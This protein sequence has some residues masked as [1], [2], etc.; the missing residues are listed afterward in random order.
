MKRLI[1]PTSVI[2]C[3]WVFSTWAGSP[4]APSPTMYTL[5]DIYNYLNYG[6]TAVAGGHSLEPVSGAVPG[7]VR[8][9]T[10]SQVYND[11]KAKFDQCD[12][13][14]I[15][16]KM[17]KKFFSARPGKWGVQTGSASGMLLQTGTWEVGVVG[18]DGWYKMGRSFDYADNGDGTVS[19]NVTGLMWAKDGAG[20]GCYSGGAITGWSNAI[21]WADGLTFAGYSDW[22]L[23]NIIEME[24]LFY[25]GSGV[26]DGVPYIQTYFPN[27]APGWYY[28]STIYDSDYL[29]HDIYPHYF[30]ANFASGC[31]DHREAIDT[32][33][34]Y[35]RAVRGGE[36]GDVM[37][38]IVQIGT[39]YAATGRNTP[40][41]YNDVKIHHTTAVAWAAG[42][43]YAGY[44]SGWRL[45]TRTELTA[46]CNEREKVRGYASDDYWTSTLQAAG[47]YYTVKFYPLHSCESG[48]DPEDISRNV[49]VVRDS[50]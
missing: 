37:P 28:S 10:T 18:E 26:G 46:I 12:A 22:R 38:P 15:D 43:D 17:G 2:L 30:Y 21:D 5:E 41:T 16:V 3:A 4:G 50:I 48:D 39:V 36:L 35:V 7:D 20:A 19:D 47:R 44:S 32:V 29:F 40:G 42:L 13:A 45:P 34:G 24:S 23:P 31:V 27:T 6:T 49:R 11:V 8:F 9:K 1:V 14:D 25:Y 33:L